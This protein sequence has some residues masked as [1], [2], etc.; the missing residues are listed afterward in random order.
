[1]ERYEP[2]KPQPIDVHVGS[3]LKSKRIAIGMS[4]AA[5]GS[6]IGV[7]FQQVQKYE[8]GTNRLTVGKLLTLT[9]LLRVPM[10]YFFRG[11]AVS[12][13]VG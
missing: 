4:Q 10:S 2:K 11:F 1:M 7:S 3:R 5:L 9:Q 13:R 6:A 12:E 8:S